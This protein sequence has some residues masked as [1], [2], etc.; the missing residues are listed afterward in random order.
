MAENAEADE[1]FN[2]RIIEAFKAELGNETL[3]IEVQSLKKEDTSAVI[4]LSE[5]SRRMQE[6][7]RSY[8]QQFAGMSEMFKDEFTLVLNANNGLIKKVDTLSGED[9]KMVCE[10][11]YDLAMLCH[12]PLSGEQM[13]KFVERSNKLMEKA[14]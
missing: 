10:H 13:T 12:R 2:N 9:R 11:I 8:G 7:Y 1:E 6:M 5:E 14:L 4:L 3:K